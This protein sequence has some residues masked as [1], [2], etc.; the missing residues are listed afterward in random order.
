MKIPCMPNYGNTG[1]NENILYTTETEDIKLVSDYTRT[2]F[3]DC[4]KLSCYDFRI[5]FRDAYIFKLKQTEEG[6]E[7][8]EN[9][10][11]LE[12]EQPDRNSLRRLFKKGL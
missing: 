11:L 7:Y 3:S 5:L 2:S 10:Y 12:Q 6:K 4:L 9:C 1:E 8:L